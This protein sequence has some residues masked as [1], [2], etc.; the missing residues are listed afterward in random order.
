MAAASLR[1]SDFVLDVGAGIRPQCLIKAKR[2]LCV[3]PH[4][5]YV[6][7]LRENGYDVLQSTAKDALCKLSDLDTVIM[8]D[9]IEHM[10]KDDGLEVMKLCQEKARQVVIFTPLGF[11]VQAYSDGDKD[12]WG[13]NGTDWQ[14][15]RSGWKPSEF[16]GWRTYCDDTFH[17][18][19]GGAFFAIW[20]RP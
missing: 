3:E 11:C 8:L 7:W 1:H 4:G 18:D 10:E 16:Q 6:E 13:M 12:A 5:E 20:D 9:V 19:R 2:H 14:T 17:G 15:H